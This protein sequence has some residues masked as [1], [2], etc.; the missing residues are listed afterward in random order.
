MKNIIDQDWFH[1]DI[2]WHQFDHT[3]NEI[4]LNRADVLAGIDHWCNILRE[5]ADFGPGSTCIGMQEIADI[6]YLTLMWAV[7][8]MGGR[9]VSANIDPAV[10]P[11]VD[12]VVYNQEYLKIDES[13]N[14]TACY[15]NQDLFDSICSRA[16]HVI[17]ADTWFTYTA[18]TTQVYEFPE[19]NPHDELLMVSF[20]GQDGK[21]ETTAFTHEFFNALS[22]RQKNLFDLGDQERVLHLHVINH[23]GAECQLF[24]PSLRF[25]QHHY[26]ATGKDYTRHS[27]IVKLID[28]QKISRV[29]C[30]GGN[31]VNSLLTLS[32]RFN[33]DVSFY[34][35]QANYKTWV[36]LVKEKNVKQV[37][38]TYGATPVCGPVLLN[39]L[40]QDA[41]DTFDVLNFGKPLDDFYQVQN[42]DGTA[43]EVTN[44]YRGA[45]IVHDCFT[46]DDQGNFVFHQKNNQVRIRN[47]WTSV[48]FFNSLNAIATRTINGRACLVP[49]GVYDQIYL[50]VD[51]SVPQADLD[52]LVLNIN[53][54]LNQHHNNYCIDHVMVVDDIAIFLNDQTPDNSRI[55]YYCRGKIKFA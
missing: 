3:G 22:Q 35:L 52:Q 9:L 5:V 51:L 55:R 2:Q 30:L 28:Q 53:H 29:N 27:G 20:T 39:T 43:I 38:S 33:H 7:W 45:K 12:C 34:L 21:L 18:D 25:C 50:L 14:T 11:R 46:N 23:G 26:H 49:D 37:V 8:R 42:I 19:I 32:P 41:D 1:P 36:S 24:L 40:T 48:D 44:Q 15:K 54:R 10:V 13:S 31:M 6:R 47:V 17:E 4:I 16:R